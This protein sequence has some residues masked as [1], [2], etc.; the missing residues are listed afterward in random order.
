MS[1]RHSTHMGRAIEQTGAKPRGGHRRDQILDAALRLFGQ[2]GMAHVTTRQIAQAV[3]ISQ[4]SLYAHFRTADEIA[5][6]LCV[7]AFAALDA[8][9]RAVVDEP[10]TPAERLV[11]A[12]RAYIDFGLSNPDMYRIA[13]VLENMKPCV[14][15]VPGEQPPV[16]PALMEGI[17]VFDLLRRVVAELRGVDD[18][19]T[20]IC[21]QAIW[22]HVHG[23][24]S[25]LI[26]RPQFPWSDRNALI[27]AHLAMLQLAEL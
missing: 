4:P 10:G 26:A 6:E 9:L 27:E 21:A 22:A 17:R 20:N 3:G 24:V 14:A 12:G 25:L 2:H 23:L 1:S 18:E 5:M 7:R 16:D 11:M 8:R 13:F 19:R 15:E